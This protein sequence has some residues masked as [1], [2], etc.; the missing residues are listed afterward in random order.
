MI[1]DGVEDLRNGCV[2]IYYEHDEAKKV[3]KKCCKVLFCSSH[4]TNYS[5]CVCVCVCVC[6]VF[7]SILL[8]LS[9]LVPFA[10]LFLFSVLSKVHY[11]TS[12]QRCFLLVICACMV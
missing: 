1:C 6:V 11:V 4:E 2:K 8:R 7:L 3:N 12:F 9:S 10:Q 5:M